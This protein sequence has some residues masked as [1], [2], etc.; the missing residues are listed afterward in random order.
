MES[1][2]WKVSILKVGFFP[3]T[4]T[5]KN[6]QTSITKLYISFPLKLYC[7]FFFILQ[8]NFFYNLYFFIGFTWKTSILKIE[9]F[10]LIWPSKIIKYLLQNYTLRLIKFY[11][12]S[13]KN[14]FFIYIF[15]RVIYEKFLLK[16]WNSFPLV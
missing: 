11:F 1:Y 4:I 14:T 13:K 15:Y 7:N 9:V 10:P 16:G 2:I 5:L 6:Y 12:Y 3:L 8:N